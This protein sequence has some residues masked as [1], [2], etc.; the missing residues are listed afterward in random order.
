MKKIIF[1]A[2]AIIGSV[3]AVNAQ[4]QSQA[5]VKVNVELNPF[6]SIEIGSGAGHDGPVTSGYDDEVTLK[7]EKAAD[8]TKGVDKTIA[9]QLKVS[10]VGSGYKIKANLLANGQFKKESGN[11]VGAYDAK[12]LIEIQVGG[13]S[14]TTDVN[15]EFGPFGNTS[16][17]ES[18]V[19]NKELDVKYIGKPLDEAAV[20]KLLGNG[21]KDAKAKYTIDVVYTIAAN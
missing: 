16:T 13:M 14:A 11:G 7:Y 20:K 1:F 6:Q 4:S 2:A 8:Y 17:A 5:K 12:D 19:L 9:K 18:S 10:S 3:T 15:M 21:G